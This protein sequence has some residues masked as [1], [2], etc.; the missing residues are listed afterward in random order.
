MPPASRR[1]IA[2]EWIIF[3]ISMGLGGHIVLGIIL[4][5]PD[6]WPWSRAGTFA[7]LLGLAV[8]L[9]VQLIRSLWWLLKPGR[10]PLH[11]ES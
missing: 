11:P 7:L 2:R 1:A 10:E 8:Y 5:A 6:A 3:A 9:V 4:H